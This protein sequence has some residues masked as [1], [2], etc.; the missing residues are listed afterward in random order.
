MAGMDVVREASTPLGLATSLARV[1]DGDRWHSARITSIGQGSAC[2]RFLFR[3]PRQQIESMLVPQLGRFA[4][5]SAVQEANH[6][7]LFFAE[8]HSTL[9]GVGKHGW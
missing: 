2:L 1:F 8:Q 3:Q 5:A 7:T 4:I 6:W 9:P